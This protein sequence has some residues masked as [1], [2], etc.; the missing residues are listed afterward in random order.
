MGGAEP[1]GLVGVDLVVPADD[2]LGA[3]LAEHVREV[4]GEAVVVVDQEDHSRASAS[5]IAVSSAASFFRHSSCS[6]A[7]TESATI[8]APACRCATPS[9]STIV[10][11]AMHVSSAPP[12]SE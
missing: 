3:E 7:G 2:D 8:P 1:I 12:G 9:L 10:R 6:S 11:I 5:S 4:V